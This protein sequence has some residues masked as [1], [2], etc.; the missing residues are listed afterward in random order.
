VLRL[1]AEARIFAAPAPVSARKG[2]DG[3]VRIVRDSFKEDPFAGDLFCFFSPS[4]DQVRILVWDRNGFWLLHKRL[5][6]GRFERI[7]CRG[8]KVELDRFQ[9]AML[10]EGI[11]TRTWRFSRYFSR[12]VRISSREG[13][14]KH[15]GAAERHRCAEGDHRGAAGAHLP[16][17][18]REPPAAQGSLLPQERTPPFE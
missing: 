6:R 9:L 13:D 7:D 15:T 8:P 12:E 17:G 3:L 1:S 2:I 18:A 10:L 5:E 14:G 16:A 4:L 11:D